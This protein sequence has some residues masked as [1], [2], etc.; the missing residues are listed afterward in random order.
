MGDRVRDT[1]YN[2]AYAPLIGT[3]IEVDDHARSKF[4][5]HVDFGGGFTFWYMPR[6]LT[7]L[8]DN[9]EVR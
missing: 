3:V 9:K 6:E 2:G 5:V 7:K 4:P 1:A 8:D